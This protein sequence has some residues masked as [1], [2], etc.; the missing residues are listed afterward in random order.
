M[1]PLSSTALQLSS[2]TARNCGETQW[3]ALS[4]KLEADA[5]PQASEGGVGA[6]MQQ[7]GDAAALCIVCTQ[8]SR[9]ECVCVRAA[10]V[11]TACDR[12]SC[13]SKVASA[14]VIQAP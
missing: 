7:H 9:A 5:R 6:A 13:G 14:S 10:R 8:P 2:Q 3:I 1:Q 11:S 12:A 4:V